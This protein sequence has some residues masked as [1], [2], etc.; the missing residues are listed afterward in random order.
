MTEER[1]PVSLHNVHAY[2][3]KDRVPGM[4]Q[5]LYSILPND[6][7]YES[8]KKRFVIYVTRI[9][10]EH[11]KFLQE[12]FHHLAQRHIPHQFSQRW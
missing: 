2:A 8:L 5:N 1:R 12:D 6:D 4:E 9:I 3:V 11:N 10:V 7:D